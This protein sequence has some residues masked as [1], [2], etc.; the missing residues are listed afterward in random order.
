MTKLKNFFEIITAGLTEDICNL[1]VYMRAASGETA[2]VD[3][4]VADFADWLKVKRK[5][6]LLL[7]DS[8]GFFHPKTL[9]FFEYWALAEEETRYADLIA[10]I[11]NK[12]YMDAL[13]NYLARIPL[14]NLFQSIR[15]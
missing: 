11:K 9:S 7:E 14:P 6:V 10:Y 3:V 5:L 13:A 8:H 15:A 12:M 1:T 4:P 2:L